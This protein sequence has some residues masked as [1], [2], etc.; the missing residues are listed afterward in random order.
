M[1]KLDLE[2]IVRDAVAESMPKRGATS[3]LSRN[4]SLGSLGFRQTEIDKLKRQIFD[5][6]I[7][8]KER[9]FQQFKITFKLTPDSTL[10][11]VID[12][13][14]KARGVTLAGKDD[15]VGRGR[16]AGDDD[17]TGRGRVDLGKGRF[18]RYDVDEAAED[19]LPGYDDTE[20]RG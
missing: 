1:S 14:P 8:H 16:F 18:R 4:V 15:T 10:Q 5:V 20:G 17:T 3:Q 13:L 19:N 7:P 6:L 11:T 9:N 2:K 12:Q